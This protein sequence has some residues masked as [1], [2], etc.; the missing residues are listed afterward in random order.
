MRLQRKDTRAFSRSNYE[1][2]HLA[3]HDGLA[4]QIA[5]MRHLLWRL[6][7]ALK[8]LA[9]VLNTRTVVVATLVVVVVEADVAFAIVEV[10]AAPE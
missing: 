8:A 9:K 5:R 1:L 10:V 4:T 7:R 2:T 6:G 3:N